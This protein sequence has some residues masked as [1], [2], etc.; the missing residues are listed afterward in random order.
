MDW[1]SHRKV[2]VASF[3]F[4]R[5]Q[6]LTLTLTPCANG[7]RC[8]CVSDSARHFSWTQ[9]AG[10]KWCTCSQEHIRTFARTRANVRPPDKKQHATYCTTY[11]QTTTVRFAFRWLLLGACASSSPVSTLA[12]AFTHIVLPDDLV[13][14]NC[15]KC[16][17]MKNL[18]R[19]EATEI[20]HLLLGLISTAQAYCVRRK[21]TG[22]Y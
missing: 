21:K 10:L 5:T 9:V 6:S 15:W 2:F 13:R 12:R 16:S 4:R 19:A 18:N 1:E 17:I 7:L 8:S 3:L 14:G 20:S 11:S 22:D